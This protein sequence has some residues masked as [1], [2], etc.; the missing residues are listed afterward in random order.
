MPQERYLNVYDSIV[1]LVLEDD[2]FEMFRHVFPAA[3]WVEATS[4]PTGHVEVGKEKDEYVLVVNG[5]SRRRAS[6][7]WE[8]VVLTQRSIYQAA[9]SPSLCTFRG[10][11]VSWKSAR[12]LF[13][14]RQLPDGVSY[15]PS[16]VSWGGEVLSDLV[17]MVDRE[18][19]TLPLPGYLCP[20]AF[21]GD[22][23]VALGKISS[24]GEKGYPTHVVEVSKEDSASVVEMGESEAM[25]RL[26]RSAK[27]QESFLPVFAG[28]VGRARRARVAFSELSELQAGLEKV[29]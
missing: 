10:A 18:G 21:G 16:L 22:E 25:L 2:V 17:A 15:L 23:E 28:L 14:G 12:I 1:R 19:Q 24:D 20:K 5:G 26:L 8:I 11:C 13:L 9:N 7:L 4:R 29:L 3:W 6:K 27:P